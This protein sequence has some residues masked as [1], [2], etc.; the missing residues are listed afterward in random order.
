MSLPP[1]A[2]FG[3]SEAAMFMRRLP[4]PN[5]AAIISIHGR[6]EF[7]VEADVPHR[8]DLTFDDVDVAPS[9]DMV[10]LQQS[11]N[12]RRWAE[13]NGLVEIA[14]MKSDA[15]AIIEFA[16]AIRETDGIVLCHCSGG[17]S[18][19]P[20]AALIALA[21]WLGDGTEV[22]CVREICRLRQGAVPHV[23]LIRFADELL[24]RNGRLLHAL[25]ESC[26]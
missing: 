3:Y 8:L 18:R 19:A 21:V 23:G 22:E 17:M 25:I 14:P 9:G 11:L 5:V 12:R 20:A 7:G 24:G 10:A 2:I 26:A 13:Q 4:E 1:L 15:A 6:R 16:G